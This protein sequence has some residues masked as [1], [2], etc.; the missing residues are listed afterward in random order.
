M[1]RV[2]VNSEKCKGCFLCISVCPNNCIQISEKMNKAGYKYIELI[3]TDKCK[4]C[5]FCYLV[6]PDVAIE[7]SK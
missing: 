2:K 4:F 1:K 6:C 7:V 5:G 3:N